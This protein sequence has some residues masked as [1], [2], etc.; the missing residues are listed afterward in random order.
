[1]VARYGGEEFVAL[2]AR[3]DAALREAKT[4]RNCIARCAR[5]TEPHPTTL[6]PRQTPPTSGAAT[7]S[8]R[9]AVVML[10]TTVVAGVAAATWSLLATVY[11]PEPWAALAPFV[12]A[13]VFAEFLSVDVYQARQQRITLSFSMAASMATVAAQ[14]AA[15]P[16]VNLMALRS[17]TSH[18]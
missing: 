14:P 16:L 2:L 18:R 1:V 12:A 3:A 10:W 9:G 4:T 11:R 7:P 5:P 8:P 15:A 6:E 17:S 13:A